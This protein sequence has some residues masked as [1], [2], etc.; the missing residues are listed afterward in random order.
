MRQAGFTL[1]E[2]LIVVAIMGMI[3]SV[4]MVSMDLLKADTE[5]RAAA[6]QIINQ[7]KKARQNSLS[8]A[9]YEGIFPSYGLHFE[10]G[11]SEII[12]YVNCI[13]DD[14]GDGVVNHEDN[15]AYNAQAHSDCVERTGIYQSDLALVETVELE[16]GVFIHNIEVVVEPGSDGT[17]LAKFS[18]NFLR[19]EPTVWI[20]V[21]PSIPVQFPDGVT[22][23][24]EV[25]PAGY[26]KVT[27]RDRAEKYEKDVIFYTTTL[28]EKEL[29]TIA[30]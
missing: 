29:R 13:A 5:I 11:D 23:Y 30:N 26:V 27:L 19:P 14:N 24:T 17:D 25:I 10:R 2:L 4:T 7:S 18:M 3:A 16:G 21:S 12:Y 1:V 20:T 15:F 6:N 22:R 9:E 28:I 8:V